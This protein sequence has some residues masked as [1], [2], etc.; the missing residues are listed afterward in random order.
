MKLKIAA[1]IAALGMCVSGCAS[2]IEGTTQNIAVTTTPKGGAKC[3]LTSS[4]GTYYVTTPG[5]ANVHKTKHN[6][7]VTCQLDGFKDS[8][9]VVESHFNGATVGNVLAGGVIGIGVDA[10]TGANYNYPENVEIAMD[11]AAA[12]PAAPAA[13]AT[14]PTTVV[15]AAAASPAKPAT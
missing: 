8:H 6:L 5:N 13:D 11:P 4:E 3:V 9:T 2:I 10:A 1:A 12:V 15:P 7:D 14:P